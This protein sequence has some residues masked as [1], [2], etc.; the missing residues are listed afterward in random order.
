MAHTCNLGIWEADAGRWW[1]RGQLGLQNKTLFQTT[2]RS[3]QM[4]RAPSLLC[5]WKT[6]PE[7]TDHWLHLPCT[8]MYLPLVLWGITM[9][10]QSAVRGGFVLSSQTDKAFCWLT[11]LLEDKP[12]NSRATSTIPQRL[13][14]RRCGSARLCYLSAWVTGNDSVPS[15]SEGALGDGQREWVEAESCEPLPQMV[16]EC[17]S[18]HSSST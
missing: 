2:K 6:Q 7:D 9:L 17:E 1:V 4:L 10:F 5:H 15:H 3:K 11:H 8:W 16:E 18:H 14:G 13:S 12:L